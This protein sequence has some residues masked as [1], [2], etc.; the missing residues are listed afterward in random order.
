MR[1]VHL[2]TRHGGANWLL[3]LTIPITHESTHRHVAA[4]TLAAAPGLSG[5]PERALRGQAD[6]A[7]RLK[8]TGH[9]SSHILLHI[10]L[11]TPQLAADAS[12]RNNF[13][14][15]FGLP[16]SHEPSGEK[17]FV[18]WA[19]CRRA[20]GMGRCTK[21]AR[22]TMG[23]GAGR[24]QEFCA[25]ARPLRLRSACRG[26]PRSSRT[27]CGLYLCELKHRTTPSARKADGA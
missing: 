4:S 17:T 1:Y 20:R 18:F 12:I 14:L 5:P 8:T 23:A 25:R 16:W 24:A 21:R 11:L 2:H 27:R 19:W 6:A 7:R 13:Q 15:G 3:A 26:W 10:L 22:C 9:I